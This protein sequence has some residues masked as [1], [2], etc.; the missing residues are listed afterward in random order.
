M[1]ILTHSRVSGLLGLVLL[2]A[3]CSTARV[4]MPTPNV[5]LESQRD[6][7]A[8]LVTGTDPAVSGL[9]RGLSTVDC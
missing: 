2:L 6:V 8:D 3:G 7:Y 9:C 1:Q 5:H 4:M